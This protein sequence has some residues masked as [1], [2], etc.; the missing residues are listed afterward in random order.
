MSDNR[1]GSAVRDPALLLTP[2]M[3][4]AL[5]LGGRPVSAITE[6]TRLQQLSGLLLDFVTND[7]EQPRIVPQIEG[8]LIAQ[9]LLALNCRLRRYAP[10]ESFSERI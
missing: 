6:R 8:N 7:P 2:V 1:I 10:A 4:I 3:I 9:H 5:V